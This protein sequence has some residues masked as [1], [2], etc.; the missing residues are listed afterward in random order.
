MSNSQNIKP[1][2][3]KELFKSN[4]VYRIPIYQRNYTWGKG[5]VEQLIQDILDFSEINP[6]K[7]YYIG[8]LVVY[9]RKENNSTIYETI[10]G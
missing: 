3:I 8:T 4:D 6:D 7:I 9:E 2:K 5:Q 1:L 10:D